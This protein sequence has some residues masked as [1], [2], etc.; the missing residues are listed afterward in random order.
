MKMN[1]KGFTLIE[2]LIVIVIIGILAMIAVPSY[3]GQQKRAARTEA[4]TN[5]QNLRLLQEQLFAD[6]GSYTGTLGVA[7]A[8]TAANLAAIQGVL[9][10]FQPGSAGNLAYNYRINT[11]VKM[12]ATAVPRDVGSTAAQTPC[13]IAVATGVSSR[14]K[15][16]IIAIDCNNNRNF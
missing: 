11:N 7:S 15:G 16:D 5:L 10:R 6:T 2:L 12:T 1:K 13:F 4:Y 9:P 8:T 14:V 3:V